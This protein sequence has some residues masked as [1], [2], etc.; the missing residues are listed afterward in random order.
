M[1]NSDLDEFLLKSVKNY[2]MQDDSFK[3]YTPLKNFLIENT[4]ELKDKALYGF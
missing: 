3:N 1:K 4:L 2:E